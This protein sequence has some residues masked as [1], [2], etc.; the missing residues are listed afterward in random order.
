MQNFL[1]TTTHTI[2]WFIKRNQAEELELTAPFQRN[3][4]WSEKQQSY[5]IDSILRGFPVPEL[6]MQEFADEKGNERFVVVD[7]QQRLRACIGFI[8]DDFGL[9]PDD[10]PDFADMKFSD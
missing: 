1:N 2:S 7:G 5:L 3:P 9:D 8:Q 6:Y 10:S 4:V